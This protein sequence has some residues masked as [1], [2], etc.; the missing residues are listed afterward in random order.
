MKTS[1]ETKEKYMKYLLA[2]KRMKVFNVNDFRKKHMIGAGVNTFLV[3]REIIANIGDGKWRWKGCKQ[4]LESL[5]EEYF[6]EHNAY[7]KKYLSKM[8]RKR[9]KSDRI[10][11]VVQIPEHHRWTEEAAIRFLKSSPNYTYEIFRVSKE[12][13]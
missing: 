5:L 13:L 11:S 1:S 10:G 12:Q 7:N 3:R 8:R 6:S 9:K 2:M 4:S